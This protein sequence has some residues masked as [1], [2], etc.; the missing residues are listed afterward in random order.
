MLL[1]HVLQPILPFRVLSIVCLDLVLP[2]ALRYGSSF[3]HIPDCKIV[4]S[5]PLQV[6]DFHNLSTCPKPS[7]TLIT[8]LILYKLRCSLLMCSILS[9]VIYL[10]G[11]KISFVLPLSHILRKLTILRCFGKTQ[12]LGNGLKLPRCK[13]TFRFCIFNFDSVF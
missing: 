6:P 5:S 2:S 4:T 7:T 10:N 12:V 13:P 11:R 9:F 1:Q 3:Y 8:C